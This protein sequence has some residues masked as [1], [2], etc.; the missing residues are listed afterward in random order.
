M[1]DNGQSGEATS[2]WGWL[3]TGT[4]FTWWA[5]IWP[6]FTR[7]QG[8]DARCGLAIGNLHQPITAT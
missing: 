4:S 5:L 3:V 7:L 8:V 6:K 1:C 2:R